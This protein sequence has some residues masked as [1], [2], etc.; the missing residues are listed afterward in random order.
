MQRGTAAPDSR[1][2]TLT[3]LLA[4]IVALAT[5]A[6]FWGLGFGLPHTNTRP[7][8]TIIIDVALSFLLGNFRPPFYDYPWLYMWTV[9]GLYLLPYAWGAVTGVF[10]SIADLLASWHVAWVPFFMM[11]RALSAILGTATVLVV[12]QICRH[13]WDH[14]TGL[15]AALFMALAFLHVRDSHYA[16]TDVTMT[17]LLMLSLM[18]LVAG[19]ARNR[20]RDFVVGG[21]IGSLAMATKYNALLLIVPLRRAIC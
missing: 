2:R 5:V 8:E 14:T 12:F 16:T 19:H 18:F 7:D 4:L 20:R 13:L 17:F 21:L 6:R 11:A 10:H 15:V 3:V 9:A 1:R